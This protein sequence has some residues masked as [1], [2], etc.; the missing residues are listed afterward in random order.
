MNMQI[1]HVNL[2]EVIGNFRKSL[3]LRS[4]MEQAPGCISIKVMESPPTSV[5][6]RIL[7]EGVTYQGVIWIKTLQ[8]SSGPPPT[9]PRG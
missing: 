6:N 7:V 8:V 5:V 3:K 2:V 4:F 9:Q 1:L